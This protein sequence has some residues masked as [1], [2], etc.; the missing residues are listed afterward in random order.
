VLLLGG[1]SLASRL[2]VADAAAAAEEGGGGCGFFFWEAA[3]FFLAPVVVVV[4]RVAV[5]A[6]GFLEAAEVEEVEVEEAAEGAAF[7]FLLL[8]EGEDVAATE[9]LAFLLLL[10]GEGEEE[11]EE[12]ALGA[13][14]SVPAPRAVTAPRV[15]ALHLGGMVMVVEGRI[16]ASGLVWSKKAE[17][18]VLLLLLLLMMRVARVATTKDGKPKMVMARST[19]RMTRSGSGG[20]V[21]RRRGCRRGRGGRRPMVLMPVGPR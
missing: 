3:F 14:V 7:A 18:V 6:L 1:S 16:K 2:S 10:E 19:I 20:G 17:E 4:L 21:T 9:A 5:V 11:D 15:L 8:L 13:V 12:A